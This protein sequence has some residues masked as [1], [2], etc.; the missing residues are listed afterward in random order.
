MH[1]GESV[2]ES[3]DTTWL[4]VYGTLKPGLSNYSA[5]ESYVRSSLLSRTQGILVDLRAFPAMVNGVGIVEGILLE[6]EPVAI[7]IADRIEGFDGEPEGSL[8]V[9][10]EVECQLH[11]ESHVMAW[12]YFFAAPEKIA[13]HQRCLVGDEDGIPV[14]RW[15][16]ESTSRENFERSSDG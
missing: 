12:T 14:F 5:L 15:P 7:E 3:R 6:V 9:R 16:V 1:K 10:K 11:D 2:S 4:F 8:Y 13:Q